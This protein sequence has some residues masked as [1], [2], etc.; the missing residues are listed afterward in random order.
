MEIDEI[1]LDA[2]VDISTIDFDVSIYLLAIY[3][4]FFIQ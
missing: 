1:D 3:L 2:V 4:F